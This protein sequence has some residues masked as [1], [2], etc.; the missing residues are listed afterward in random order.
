MS[1]R[2]SY[3]Q[4]QLKG[5]SQDRRRPTNKSPKKRSTDSGYIDINKIEFTNMWQCRVITD[6]G[7]Y[8][9]FRS[10]DY[11]ECWKWREGEKTAKESEI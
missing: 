7:Y 11:Y 8:T 6:Y 9:A 4:A 5:N 3:V 1:F 10:N 2:P